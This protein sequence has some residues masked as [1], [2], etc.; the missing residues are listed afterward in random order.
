MGKDINCTGFTRTL[1]LGTTLHVYG[2]ITLASGMTLTG[3]VTIRFLGRGTHTITSAGIVWPVGVFQV[4]MN[5][6]S[7]TGGGTY[8]LSDALV[9]NHPTTGTFLLEQ[10]CTFTT[11]NFALTVGTF[12]YANGTYATL[13]LGSS[14]VTCYTPVGGY[15]WVVSGIWT[16]N[17]G[18]STINLARTSGTV[19]QQFAGSGKTYYNLAISSTLPVNDITIVHANT[20]NNISVAAGTQLT[21]PASTTNTI[22]GKL[23]ANGVPNVG[24][25]SLPGVAGNEIATTTNNLS[26]LASLEFRI[27][28]RVPSFRPATIQYLCGWDSTHAGIS[29]NT[30]G[31]LSV[32][33]LNTPAYVTIGGAVSSSAVPANLANTWVWLRGKV[34]VSS[35]ACDF[36]YSSD[37]TNDNTAVSWT[38]LG[39]GIVG[40]NAGT[41]PALTQSFAVVMGT[42]S[43]GLAGMVGDIRS[44]AEYVDGTARCYTNGISKTFGANNFTGTDGQNYV[45]YGALAQ[46]G[47][48]RVALVSSTPATPATLASPLRQSCDYLTVQ[49]STATGVGG[50]YA[51]AHSVSV[52]GNSG[53]LFKAS[54][55]GN[56]FAFF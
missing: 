4:G 5:G 12:G 3:A 36:Y 28:V 31:A 41:T 42:K 6:A 52:S 25:V 51:G 17:A 47:D 16:I 19:N 1:N 37:N 34:T 54:P 13:N 53:W 50:W 56:F 7:A 11:N 27:R 33:V 43:S 46:A 2:S 29:F 22:N 48:G 23:I 10:A 26:S 15:V 9:L 45:I 24:Y 20:F 44:F 21:M 39:T 8:S 38:S 49:D 40:S 55:S 30:A 18:T 32:L 35:A 14:N